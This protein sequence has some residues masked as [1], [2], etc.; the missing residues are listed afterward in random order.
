MTKLQTCVKEL[1]HKLQKEIKS[2]SDHEIECQFEDKWKEWMS[3]FITTGGQVMEYPS[4]SEMEEEIVNIL[5]QQ[6]QEHD[7]LIVHKL[8][9][10]PLNRR[11]CTLQF[12][13]D[14]DIHLSSTRW[15]GFASLQSDD[16]ILANKLT[17]E[18]LTSVRERMST[19]QTELKPF[20]VK[21]VHQL[22]E[23]F[24]RSINDVMNSERKSGFDFSLEYRI[25]MAL[26]I[27]VFMFDV[28]KQTTRKLKDGDPIVKLSEI[29]YVFLN[30]FKDLC[31]EA[32]DVNIVASHKE[33]NA[34]TSYVFII[35]A[36]IVIVIAIAWLCIA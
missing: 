35:I 31:R 30:M 3:N 11:N 26:V 16:V 1:A 29:K 28:F 8:F 13:V 33:G 20:T 36:L 4:D 27:C 5:R 10:K 18:C 17:Q 22:V 32:G 25:D 6:L 9:A 7:N 12:V 19:I 23:C 21:L 24:L 14:K 2:Y 34:N 15:L